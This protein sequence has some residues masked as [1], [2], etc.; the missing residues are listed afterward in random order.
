MTYGLMFILFMV[1][2]IFAYNVRTYPALIFVWIFIG[3]IVF[4]VSMSLAETYS[5]AANSGGFTQDAYESWEGNNFILSNLPW[6]VAAMW[7]VG[8]VILFAVVTKDEQSE[9]LL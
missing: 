1:F 9:L 7:L 2:A 6:V 8:G 4:F 5:S 3:L